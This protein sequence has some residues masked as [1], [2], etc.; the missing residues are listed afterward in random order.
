MK[1]NLKKSKK[2]QKNPTLKEAGKLL[3]AQKIKNKKMGPC[4]I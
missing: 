4:R 1:K 3:F 2:A